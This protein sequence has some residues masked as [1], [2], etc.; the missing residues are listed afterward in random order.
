[1]KRTSFV[2]RVWQDESGRCW[3]QIVEPVAEKRTAFKSK[4]ALLQALKDHLDTPALVD[5]P[6]K[7]RVAS[8]SP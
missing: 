7:A 3:G 2:I 8:K 4:D 5:L 1:M 6:P